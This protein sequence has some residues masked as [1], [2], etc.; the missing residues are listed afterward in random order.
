MVGESVR[1]AVLLGD[2][3][4]FAVEVGDWEGSALR[5]VDLWAADQWLTCDDNSGYVPAFR[6][7]VS[8]TADAVRAGHGSA[9]PFTGLSPAATHRR[10]LAA[11]TD[12]DALFREQ[13]WIFYGWGPTTDNLTAF[14]FRDGDNLTL[15]FKFW[16]EHDPRCGEVFVA[17]FQAGAFAGVLDELVAILGRDQVGP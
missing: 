16:R 7:A 4:M 5:R 11:T 15:T 13:F 6:R 9:L 1:M 2:K 3:R 14:L 12:E 10:F 17:E 8:N